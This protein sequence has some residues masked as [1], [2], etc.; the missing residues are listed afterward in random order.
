MTGGQDGAKE[1]PE[2]EAISKHLQEQLA[3]AGIEAAIL[4]REVKTAIRYHALSDE[5]ARSSIQH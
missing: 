2:R 4:E 3:T 1:L 5:K